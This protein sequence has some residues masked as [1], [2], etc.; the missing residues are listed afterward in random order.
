[1]INSKTLLTSIVA[2]LIVVFISKKLFTI[3]K[4]ES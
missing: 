4:P 2:G 3:R 1:M